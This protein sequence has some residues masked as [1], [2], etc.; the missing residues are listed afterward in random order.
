M[1]KVG[2][3]GASGYTGLELVR[4]LTRHPEVE[5]TAVTSETYQGQKIADVFP[6]FSGFSELVFAS[7]SPSIASECDFLFLALPHT[8]AMN[9]V[10]DFLTGNCRVIDLSADFRLKSAEI[11]E[12]WYDVAH[13]QV[14]TLAESVY[15]LPEL[16]REAIRSARLIANPGCYPTSVILA[17]APLLT[18]DWVDFQSIIADC[19]SGVSGAG[20]KPSLRTQFSECNEAVSAYGLGTHRHTPEIEQEISALAGQDITI[21]FSP[22]LMPM[23][24]GML[25][26]VYIN[27]TSDMELEALRNH[28]LEFYKD[29]PFVRILNLGTFANTHY[30]VSSNYCDIGLQIDKRARRIVLTS[31]ID[32]LVKGASGQAIQNMNIMLGI[33]EKTALDSPGIFP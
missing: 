31:A 33:D 26:T 24:R 7:L 27:L 12:T 29:E 30:V 8:T 18:T 10:P 13:E 21:S 14:E 6:S 1:V 16:H 2:I 9:R 3:A 28:Y 5:I 20:R 19:K 22:H 17:L 25:S 11:F 4:L 23:T 15:G 32:N